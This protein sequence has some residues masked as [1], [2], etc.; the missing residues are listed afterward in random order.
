MARH[1][2]ASI[3]DLPAG[4]LM[5]VLVDGKPICLARTDGP[6]LFA[7]SDRC[8]H[9]EA[10]LSEG[11]ILGLEVECPLHYSRFDLATGAATAPPAS[12]PVETYRVTVEDGEVYIES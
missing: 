12:A 3:R 8:T 7:V 2:V 4:T 5:R 6:Q 9:E 10:S 1:R 11:E